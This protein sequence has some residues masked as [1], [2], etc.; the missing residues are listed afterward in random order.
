MKRS[1]SKKPSSGV[2]E[3]CRRIHRAFLIKEEVLRR[4]VVPLS[5]GGRRGGK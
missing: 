3:A 2:V 1:D 5:G 4:G